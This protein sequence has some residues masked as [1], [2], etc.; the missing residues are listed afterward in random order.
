MLMWA[1]S[2]VDSFGSHLLAKQEAID[3]RK[4]KR[5]ERLSFEFCVGVWS[6]A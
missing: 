5:Q 6:F 2:C 4:T 3:G 1:V